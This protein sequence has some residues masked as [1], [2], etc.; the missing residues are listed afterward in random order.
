MRI[1]Q[2]TRIRRSG[3][4]PECQG[5]RSGSIIAAVRLVMMLCCS[6]LVLD[7]RCAAADEFARAMNRGKAQLENRNSAKAIEA[8]TSAV[9]ANP[10]SAAAWR[11]LA[12]ARM[13]ANRNEEALGD[14]NRARS[15]EKESAATSY[16]IGLTHAHGSRFEQA[17]PFLE[18]AARLDAFTATVRFQLALAYQL[19][20]QRDKALTQL[21]ET[22]RLDPLHASAHFKLGAYAAQAGDQIEFERRQQEFQRLR[23]IFADDSRTPS[24]LERCLYTLPE[25]APAA[26]PKAEPAMPVRFEDASAVMFADDASRA[27]A[28]AAVLEVDAQ[29]ASTVFVAENSGAAALLRLDNQG[30]LA[31]TPLTNNLAPCAPLL[32][33]IAG[34]FFDDVPKGVQY[35]PE[36]HARNDVFLVGG[37]GVCLLKRT[38]P[39]TFE[40]VTA[41][42][43]LAGAHARRAQ[44]VDYDHDGDLDLLLARDT[45]LQLWQNNGN[46]HFSNVTEHAGLVGTTSTFDAVAV[47]LDA[48]VAVDVVVAQGTQPSV[49]FMNQRAGRFARLPEPPGPWPPARR[50][51]ANDLDNDGYMDALLV[52]DKEALVLFGGRSERSQ[53][54]LSALQDPAIVLFDFDNDGWLDV[55]A[56]GAT[57]GHGVVRLW[58]NAAGHW[59]EVTAATGLTSIAL[60]PLRD[61]L[62]ADLDNEGDTDL[63]VVTAEGR[64]H[65]LRNLGGNGREQLKV[66]LL[67]T[68]TNPSGIGTRIE[69]TAAAFRVVRAL[70]TLPVEIGLGRAKQLDSVQ[71]VWA[72][73]IVE[74]QIDVPVSRVPLTILEKNVAAGSCPYLY[75]WDGQQFRFATDLLGNSPLGLSLRRDTVLPADPD[76]MVLVGTAEIFRPRQGFY[77]VEV[78]EELR[79]ALYL[80]CAR[81]VAVDHPSETEIHATDRLGPPPFPPSELRVLEAVRSP[82]RVAG[83]DGLDR[84]EAVRAIDG[85]FAPPGKSLPPPLRGLC[86]PLALTMDFGPLTVERPLALAL[87]GWIQYGDASVNIAASQNPLIP[88]IPPRLEVETG[89]EEWTAVEVTVGMPAGKTKTILCDLSGKL[90]PGARRLR[91]T[92]TFELHWDRIALGE[93]GSRDKMERFELPIHAARL[94]ER[95]YSEIASRAP[96]HPQTPDFGKVTPRPPWRTTPQGWCTRYGD[97]TDLVRKRDE[98][99]VVMNGGDA[100][101]VR[102]DGK[103]LP[104]VA[105]GQERTFF[106]YSV[107]WDKDADPNVVQGDTVDPLPVKSGDWTV[108]FNTRWVQGVIDPISQ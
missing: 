63:V 40:D 16:L 97:V 67:G 44:W 13:L 82:L 35:D 12:R 86:E 51:L 81:L 55:C 69:A 76:E 88:V 107:G 2:Q 22:V 1:S 36:V 78:T 101:N 80:D 98:R 84:T 28:A 61:A 50:V 106:F 108:K 23:K 37:G 33:C 73:G 30:R 92:T 10:R 21:R 26:A 38:G 34:D 18:E 19:A 87:T 25:P 47:D 48:N 41:S 91:L 46:G 66:R 77:E 39:A 56:V 53:L 79:E 43:G 45:G 75:G 20:R 72:N 9:N 6:L 14:L 103:R 3:D 74:N 11:N 102:F 94:Y 27:A 68:K 29:G 31:R 42:A 105:E 57:A 90:P 59:S 4:R 15:L 52:S 49:V 32:Q 89:L 70:T 100:L 99:L 104:P 65:F 54:D 71:T 64:L 96:G 85:V 24:S 58:R 83:S 93:L 8:F 7:V 60:P 5:P 62:A 17:I 95:G